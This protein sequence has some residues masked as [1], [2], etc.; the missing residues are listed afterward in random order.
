MDLKKNQIFELEITAMSSDGN[1][2]GKIDGFTVF[3]PQTAIG[4]VAKVKIIKVLKKYAVGKLDSV[5]TSSKDRIK[6]DCPVF[7]QCGGCTFRHISYEAELRIKEDFIKSAY[8]RIGGIALEPSPILS[9][10]RQESYR[11][12]AQFPVG[13]AGD[14]IVYGFYANRS[15]RI[16]ECNNCK[17]QPPVFNQIADYVVAFMKKNDIEP[18][19][20]ISQKGLVRHIYLRK[21]E[22]TDEIM[23]CLV[24]TEKTKA[25]DTMTE[26]I[27]SKFPQIKSILINVNSKNT[28]VIMGE[29]NYF[30]YGTETIKDVLLDNYF[31]LSPHSFYQVNSP[32]TEELYKKVIELADLNGNETVID[33]YCGVGTIGL[34]LAKKVKKLLGIEIVS[35][36]IENAKNNA[37][38]NGIKNA[39]FICADASIVAKQHINPDIIIIDPPRKGCDKE[40]LDAIVNFSPQKIIMVSCDPATGARDAGYLM[41][42]GYTPHVIQP[43]DLFPRTRHVETVC[44]LSKLETKQHIEVEIKMDE[45]DL[46]AAESKATYDEIKAYVLEHTG[47]KVS[48]LYISQ[49]KRKCGLG[50]GQNYNLS[51]KEDAKVPQCPP[52]KEKAIE[53]AFK[54]FGML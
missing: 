43:V 19:D 28:N 54:H 47:L 29:Q 2:I 34:S 37:K 7:N 5:K 26:K 32:Q 14:K 6:A 49:V 40:T 8:S 23:L 50:V 9:S 13:K 39:E 20:E 46:T 52:E 24:C 21:G 17:L 1:G 35:Q 31:E 45:L 16:I 15:H 22:R 48:S 25:F 38:I 27:V 11:N 36:A 51:K 30:I 41:E 4:D 10:K 53:E 44:L 12:K 42:K 18:Y 3:V 33:L